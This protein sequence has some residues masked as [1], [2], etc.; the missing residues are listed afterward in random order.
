MVDAEDLVAVVASAV[1][2][3]VIGA[4]VAAAVAVAA[5]AGNPS[6]CSKT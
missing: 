4:A 2:A 5:I 6:V 1:D 3:A